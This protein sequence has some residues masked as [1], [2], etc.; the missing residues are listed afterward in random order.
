MLLVPE[1]SRM[2]GTCWSS[3]A[4]PT[5]DPVPVIARL[6]ASYHFPLA[7]IGRCPTLTHPL[8]PPT[9]A[10]VLLARCTWS[11]RSPAR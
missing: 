7:T 8:R 10:T 6:S 5:W 11:S 3:Q 9:A 4:S 1:M 2:F